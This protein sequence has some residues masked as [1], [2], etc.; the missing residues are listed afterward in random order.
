MIKNMVRSLAHSFG[1][2]IS[3]QPPSGESRVWSVRRSGH[4]TTYETEGPF[5]DL[6][7]RAQ[8]HT[9]MAASDNHLRRQRHYTLSYL[10]GNALA[11]AQGDVCEVGCWRGLSAYQIAQRV[12][13]S[14]TGKKMHLF[15]SFQGLSEYQPEDMPGNQNTNIEEVR[16]MVACSLPDVQ[17]NLSEFDFIDYYQGWVPE[18][19]PEVASLKFA[20]VH[21]DV[22]LYQPIRD[23]FLFFYPLLA[24]NGIMVF[25]DYGFKL[26]PGAQQAVDEILKDL[27]DPLFVPLPSGQAFL[28]KR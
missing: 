16:S 10:L 25:D 7:E 8:A 6:Y 5:H 9:Q 21:I 22:D 28:V 20:F 11:Q 2:D 26:F 24:E 19:F 12:K 4:L 18:R 14:G 3:K 17:S 1:Y 13:D 23:T 15:D 27:D